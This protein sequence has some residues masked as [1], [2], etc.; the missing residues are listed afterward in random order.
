MPTSFVVFDQRPAPCTERWTIYSFR[1]TETTVRIDMIWQV[2]PLM[3][4][5]HG[6][7][8]K[9]DGLERSHQLNVIHQ[10]VAAA[11]ALSCRGDSAHA[12]MTHDSTPL[13]VFRISE[14]TRIIASQL[15]LTSRESAVNFAC[16]RRCSK[17]RSSARYGTQKSL[18]VL[19]RMLPKTT[20]YVDNSGRDCTVCGLDLPVPERTTLK[21]G[22]ILARDRWGSIARGLEQ[23]PTLRVLDASG[24]FG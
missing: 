11:R 17:N 18:P 19:L 13:R 3:N 5:F 1:Q 22:V 14:L 6:A 8:T 2:Y 12:T 16:T 10:L 20:W 9:C 15:I 23:G 24:P 4:E 7:A 21:L